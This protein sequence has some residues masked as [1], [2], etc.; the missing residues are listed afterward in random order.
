MRRLRI[1]VW[2]MALLGSI[3]TSGRCF[4][5][6]VGTANDEIIKMEALWTVSDRALCLE[7]ETR[8]SC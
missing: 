6:T 7:C 3:S 8:G 4:F 2:Q 5:D 1:Q